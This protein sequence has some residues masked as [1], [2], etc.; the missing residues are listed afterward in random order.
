MADEAAQ[1]SSESQPKPRGKLSPLMVIG[2]L[3]AVEGIAV[4]FAA[5]M[6]DS[7]PASAEAALVEEGGDHAAPAAEHG[8]PAADHGGAA[9]S[10]GGEHGAGKAVGEQFAEIELAECR[11][12]NK[13]TGKLVTFHLKVSVLVSAADKERADAAAKS[14]LARIQDAINVVM[15]SAEP[16]QLSEPGLETLRRRLKHEFDKIFGDETLIK[17]VL[18]PQLLQSGSGV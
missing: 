10:G 7:A 2:A 8:A 17:Q 4:F 9:E 12:S 11:P 13:L 5:R 3:M 14:R 1:T 18:I 16:A 6:F 15:R